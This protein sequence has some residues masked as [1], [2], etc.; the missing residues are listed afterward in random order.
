MRQFLI[1][2]AAAAW[3]AAP[4]AFADTIEINVADVQH[5]QTE[6]HTAFAD[7]MEID[8][9]NLLDSHP[10]VQ[11]AIPLSH[12]SAGAPGVEPAGSN[13]TAQSDY[14]QLPKHVSFIEP[15]SKVVSVPEP[16]TALLLV[17]GLLLLAGRRLAA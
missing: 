15:M 8:T 4:F 14:V 17:S 12:F 1:V 9:Q 16:G 6:T 13:L 3:L 5:V 7:A 11:P 10:A 2:I